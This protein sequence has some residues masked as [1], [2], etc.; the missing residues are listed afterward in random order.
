MHELDT[1][2]D[3]VLNDFRLELFAELDRRLASQL[4]RFEALT[5][6]MMTLVGD[7][8][9]NLTKNVREL[10]RAGEDIEGPDLTDIRSDLVSAIEALIRAGQERETMLRELLTKLDDLTEVIVG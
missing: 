1:G 10:G 6:L 2:L 3:D 5:Q 9:D 4:Q 7:P 8:L